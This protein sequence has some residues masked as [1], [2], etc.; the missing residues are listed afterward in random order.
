MFLHCM[1]GC[2]SLHSNLCEAIK[3]FLQDQLRASQDL[4]EELVYQQV[5]RNSSYEHMLKVRHQ[6]HL[7]SFALHSCPHLLLLTDRSAHLQTIVPLEHA[8]L[9]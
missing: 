8:L 1:A 6:E 9:H 7:H 3:V 4:L 2:L 5:V